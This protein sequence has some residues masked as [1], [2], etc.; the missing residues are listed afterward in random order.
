MRMLERA[1]R[2]LFFLGAIALSYVFAAKFGPGSLWRGFEPALAVQSKPEKTP[3]DLTRL[4]AVNETLKYIRKKYVEPDRVKPK[5]MLVSALNYIQRDVAQ[6]IVQQ[7]NPNEVIVRVDNESKTFRVDNVQGPWDVA[8]R[9]REVF[10]FLQKHLEGTDVDLREL[11]YTACNGMLH[12]LDPHSSFLSPEAYREMNVQTSGAFGGLGIVISVRDQQLTIMK[13]MPG[14]PAGRA[15][16][17]RFD[18]VVKIENESTQNMPLDDAVR[19]LRGDPGSKVTLW[20]VREGDGGWTTPK[21]FPLT[22][23]IIKVTSVDSRA[24]DG[25]VGYVRIKNF[26]ATTA[27]EVTN[28]LDAIKKGGQLRGL[29][30]DLRGNPGGLLDQAVRVADLFVDDGVIVSTAGASEGREERRATSSGTE[31]P[32][33]I[34]VLV[35][36]SSASA[37]EILAGAL[38]N[39]KRALI[40]GQQTFGKGSVQLVFP[41]ITP[42]KAALKLTIAQYLTPGDI[43]IQ[44]V[45]VTPDIE[46]DPMTVDPLEMD[47]TMQKDGLRERELFAVL[48]NEHVAPPSKPS[49]VVRYQFTSAERETLRDLGGDADDEVQIDFPIRFGRELAAN[50]PAETAPAE[51]EKAVHKQIE[52]IKSDELAKVSAELEKIGVDWASAPDAQ[53]TAKADDLE[54]KIDTGRPNDEVEAG[55]PMELRV[56]VKNNGAN[57]V[58]RLRAQTESENG[59]FDAKELVFGK[60]GAGEERTAKVPLGWCEVEGQKY[61]SIQAKPKDAKRVCKIP[62]DAVDRSDGVTIKF[63]AD[64]GDAPLPAEVRPTVRAEPRPVFKYSYQVIDDRGGN[65]DGRIQRGEKVSMYLTVKNVGRG[66]S[67][68]TQATLT[69]LSGDGLLL[70]AGRFDVSN[71]KVGEARH[72]TFTFDVA[73]DLADPEAVV[74]LSVGDRDLNETAKE[75]VKIPI[76]PPAEVKPLALV[77]AAGS[78]G[79]TLL[80]SPT[81]GSRG[82]GHV[83]ASTALDVLGSVGAFDKIKLEGSRFAFVA[84]K[85]LTDPGQATPDSKPA[86]DDVFSHAP[87]ELTLEAGTLATRAP[88]VKIK[89]TA[90]GSTKIQDVYG[91]V[92]GRKVFYQSN[93]DAKDPKTASFEIDVQ[94]KPGVNIINVFAREDA[95]SVTRRMIVVR[96]DGD[97]GELLKTPKGEDAE[98]WLVQGGDSDD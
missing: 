11:E 77:R 70:Q 48:D 40:V 2:V 38:K 39:L 43:S 54:V 75:K 98:D 95:D 56:T 1:L 26:Q 86:F 45:G 85:D 15:G 90:L 5:Q 9:L 37:S 22:R 80:E 92:G 78:G 63:E 35:N 14:T 55:Q 96:K 67:Y 97:A 28:A 79:A 76:E 4:E 88:S 65:G 93:K 23:E 6:V 82:F 46:L 72:V 62:L 53:K 12:T 94:L 71:M 25:N 58:Y 64:G 31:P 8:A 50:M 30:L 57:P 21:P 89:G 18:R 49:D 33:P 59:Y 61:A 17:K 87:P 13:P 19:R 41:D 74:S 83:D 44:G 24:L 51:Q 10:A 20:V 34:V 91:F 27:E 60:I 3:Y 84:A 81:D 68:D 42:E 73:S 66:R 69:N 32:Y 36:G 52:R 16:V 7:E 29:V 47:L